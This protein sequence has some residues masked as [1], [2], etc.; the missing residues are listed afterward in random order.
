MFWSLPLGLIKNVKCGTRVVLALDL[1]IL[2]FFY[3]L[4]QLNPLN[5][6]EKKIQEPPN[7]KSIRVQCFLP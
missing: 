4:H 5:P 2:L 6:E 3:H 1:E 7:P